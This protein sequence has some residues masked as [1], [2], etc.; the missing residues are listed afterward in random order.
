MLY[1]KRKLAHLAQSGMHLGKRDEDIITALAQRS[2]NQAEVFKFLLGLHHLRMF[3]IF[4][5][6]EKVELVQ[7]IHNTFS[8]AKQDGIYFKLLGLVFSQE[9][10]Q[11]DEATG[12]LK[13]MQ[14]LRSLWQAEKNSRVQAGIGLVMLKLVQ[15]RKEELL[16]EA[17]IEELVS[18]IVF[19]AD[20]LHHAQVLTSLISLYGQTRVMLPLIEVFTSHADKASLAMLHTI[21]GYV[22]G[23]PL[24]QKNEIV[25]KVEA[26]LDKSAPVLGGQKK[27]DLIERF[28][29]GLGRLNY[30]GMQKPVQQA[31]GIAAQKQQPAGVNKRFIMLQQMKG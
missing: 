21:Y 26:L 28:R 10:V 23:L 29:A 5:A 6:N 16:K 13:F 20:S 8:E 12:V 25:A 19:S 15:L 11:Q 3:W 18:A 1:I 14:L 31:S 7:T 2:N 27:M 4:P 30:I 24:K 17:A 22:M 9:A